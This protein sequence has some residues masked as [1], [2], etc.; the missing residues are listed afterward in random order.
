[1]KRGPFSLSRTLALLACGIIV[2]Q[3]P[4]STGAEITYEQWPDKGGAGGIEA[5]T[6]VDPDAKTNTVTYR[7][8]PNEALRSWKGKKASE[9][10]VVMTD[11]A[12]ISTSL[13]GLNTS[14]LIIIL[15]SPKE[16]RFVDLQRNLS[17]MY[18][19]FLPRATDEDIKKSP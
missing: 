1:M 5:D 7:P 15:F 16:I 6:Y 4:S 10:E 14:K 11:G 17:G 9:P 3:P 8:N 12:Q 18:L 13:K 19:R 2:C